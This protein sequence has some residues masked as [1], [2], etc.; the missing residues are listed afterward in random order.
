MTY[1][2]TDNSSGK[3]GGGKIKENWT[4]VRCCISGWFAQLVC[5]WARWVWASGEEWELVTSQAL[6]RLV[7]LWGGRRKKKKK[8]IADAL[9]A[10]VRLW[11]LCGAPRGRSVWSYEC[12]AAERLKSVY[13]QGINYHL[14]ALKFKQD[15]L[16]PVQQL[17]EGAFEP[18]LPATL[19]ITVSCDYD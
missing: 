4:T 5:V 16:Q 1:D 13:G 3:K 7:T 8:N 19:T 17:R 11:R 15:S 10:P 9:I 14:E 18:E 12:E 6:S 2:L